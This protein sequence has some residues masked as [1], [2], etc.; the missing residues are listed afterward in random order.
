MNSI[1]KMFVGDY[2]KKMSKAIIENEK[3]KKLQ[4]QYR[5][6][7]TFEYLRRSCVV[8]GFFRTTINARYLTYDKFAM[9]YFQ[10]TDNSGVIRD[11][12]LSFDVAMILAE[13]RGQ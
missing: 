2:N 13:K 5:L 10:Y 12:S 6:G 8:T 9:L 4:E 11:D 3:I 1:A 7:D